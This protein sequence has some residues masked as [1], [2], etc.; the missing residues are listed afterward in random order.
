MELIL[1]DVDLTLLAS[2]GAGVRA[3][4]SAMRDIYGV[5]DA[6]AGVEFAGRTDRV[7]S[8]EGLRRNGIEP[9]PD[10]V[11]GLRSAYVRR[12]AGEL[13]AP[14]CTARALD[15]VKSLLDALSARP[16]VASGLLTG[17]WMEGAFLKLAA[18]GLDRYF[19]FGG[20]AEDGYQRAELVPAALS[21]AERFTGSSFTPERTWIVGDTPHD[22]ACGRAWG[23]RTLGVATG[24]YDRASLEQ[25]G[26]TAVLDD[27]GDTGAAL[28]TLLGHGGRT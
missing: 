16:D 26:A 13:T 17:N 1:F 9:L 24:P 14:G 23:V 4:D 10:A 18:C 27:L 12:L 21:E 11:T 5:R 3:L 7:I 28:G 2:G 25:S 8:E 20:F 6:F 19:A 15:G 22:V